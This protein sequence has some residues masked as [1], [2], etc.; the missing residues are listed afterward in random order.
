[1]AQLSRKSEKYL[2]ALAQKSI[3]S[4]LEKQELEFGVIPE[5]VK[6]ECGTFVTLKIGGRLRG[7]VGN[8]EAR[9]EIYKSVARNAVLAAFEDSRFY[10]ISSNEMSGIKIH[11]S[12]L[13]KPKTLEYKDTV[14]LI[15]KLTRAKPGVVLEYRDNKATFLPQVWDEV[16]D[17]NEF[18]THLCVK[19]GLLPDAWSSPDNGMIIYTYNVQEFS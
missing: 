1:M 10:P 15:D 11:V 7:C 3:V 5:D 8:I 16:A 2:L 18:L 4:A 17:A 12:I 9:D 19:A 14:D 6:T 13:S